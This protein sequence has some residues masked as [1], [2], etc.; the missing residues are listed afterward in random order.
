MLRRSATGVFSA[1]HTQEASLFTA[2]LSPVRALSSDMSCTLSISLPSAG[3]LAPVSTHMMSPTTTSRLGIMVTS[4]PRITLTSVSSPMRDSA[5]N[6]FALRCSITTEMATEMT[7]ATTMPTHSIQSKCPPVH[8][9]TICTAIVMP[10]ATSSMMSIGS[11][12][13]SRMRRAI[14]LGFSRVNSFAPRSFLLSSASEGESPASGST[15]SSAS[16]SRADCMY[17]F[18]NNLRLSFAGDRRGRRAIKKY[19]QATFGLTVNTAT[20]YSLNKGYT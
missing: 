17:S 2:M 20:P 16:T 7:I 4:P 15:P 3:S 12:I 19:P 11:H 9:E 5:S 14:D 13:A 18:M 1:A 8:T 10:S 6:A